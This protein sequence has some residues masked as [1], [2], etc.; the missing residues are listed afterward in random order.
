MQK[1]NAPNFT[2]KIWHYLLIYAAVSFGGMALPTVMGREPFILLTF[3]IGIFYIITQKTEESNR[4]LFFLTILTSSL[5][6]TFLGSDL[7]IGSILSTLAAFMFTYGI[8]ACDPQNFIQRFLKIIFI[9]S[10]LSIILYA[11]TQILG[12][13]FFFTSFSPPTCSKSR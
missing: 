11:M 7:S 2:K 12:I 9:I 10:V 13:D 4:Y 6:I 5:S 8:I 3:F 1:Y